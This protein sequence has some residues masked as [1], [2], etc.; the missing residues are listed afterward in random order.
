MKNLFCTFLLS[1]VIYLSAYAQK[2]SKK[3]TLRTINLQTAT[4]SDRT[5]QRY[6]KIDSTYLKENRKTTLGETLEKIPGVQNSYFGPYA[7]MPVIR[8]LSGNRVKILANGIGLNDLSGISPNLNLNVDF[9]NVSAIEVYKESA[10][11]L[12]G[13]RAIGGAVNLK[14]NSVPQKMEAKALSGNAYVEGATNNGYRTG[15]NFR[16]KIGKRWSW[17]AAGN[18]FRVKEI[19]IPGNTKIGLAYDKN[20]TGKNAMV[21]SLAQMNVHTHLVRNFT[22]FPYISKFGQMY[23]EEYG[24]D[25]ADLYTNSPTSNIGGKIVANDPNP[26]YIPGQDPKTVPSTLTV[27]DSLSD[28]GPVRK[29]YM[30]NSHA[31]SKSFAMGASYFGDNF[32]I[33]AGFRGN[34]NYYGVPAYALNAKPVHSH[35]ATTQTLEYVPINVRT[36]SNSMLFESGY[37]PEAGPFSMLKLNYSMQINDDRELLG[38]FQANKFYSTTHTARME[39][40][41]RQG[42]ILSGVSGF[43]FNFRNTTG[44]GDQRYLP[45]N[46]SREY[47]VFT[48]QHLDFGSLIF[49]AGYRHDKVQRR[50]M[51]DASYKT[52]RGL[53]GGKLSDRDFDLNQF[54]LTGQWNVSKFGF[55]SAGFNHSERAPDV[56][57]LYAGNDHFAIIVE[58]N[59]E[60]TLNKERATT[61]DLGAGIHFG[62]LKLSVSHYNT[63][64]NDYI[65]LAHTGISRAGGFTVKEWRQDSTKIQGWEAQAQYTWKL[66][67]KKL[68]DF[69]AFF[70]IVK[71]INN[72]SS[73]I[74]RH[75]DGDYMPNMPVS[76][77]GFSAAFM[78]KEFRVNVTLDRYM[79]Q[80]YLAKNI[81]PDY[82]MPGYS[83]MGANVSYIMPLK[84]SKIEYFLKG[85]NLL[86]QEARPQTSYLRYVAPL[87]GRNIAL[88]LRLII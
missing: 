10:S 8:S 57:E 58:E 51:P 18:L 71:N 66:A 43:D 52:G 2:V 44:K 85:N 54:S 86:N 42:K 68:L 35:T 1:T 49:D 19:R 20:I 65:Y 50:A 17:H 11:V 76:R 25:L 48:M 33:G 24:L 84:H 53:A 88:G 7:G 29:G 69:G 23:F 77:Y 39:L 40:N 31:D 5:L 9:D 36:L 70:D 83:L 55:L 60:D 81:M 59:G 45:N 16:G 12:Y 47:A 72:S 4:I 63:W 73:K 78:L 79:K 21:Q 38:I 28:Y 22:I 13:G 14:D 41:Q 56:N 46:L 30:P 87:P 26:E 61:L 34:S 37:M 27:V 15:L 80:R 74:R 75:S 82:A 67:E 32:Y 3:Q 6:S 62:G 64:F